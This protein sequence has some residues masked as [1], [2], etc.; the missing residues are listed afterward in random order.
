[1]ASKTFLGSTAAA[2]LMA[3]LTGTPARAA[4]DFKITEVYT[5]VDGEDG[6][7]DW[8]ELT[9]FGDTTGNIGSYYYDDSPPDPTHD[10]VLPN[11]DVAPCESVIVLIEGLDDPGT[12][13][14]NEEAVNIAD[15]YA[16]WGLTPADV[17]V[18][19]TDGGSLGGSGDGA[20][21]FDNNLIISNLIDSLEYTPASYGQIG[22]IED[23]H[24]TGPLTISSLGV[25]GAFESAGL[26]F[27]AP[28]EAHLIGS[29]GINICNVPEPTSVVLMLLGLAGLL[30][31]RRGN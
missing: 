9:N 7:T 2:M 29:P 27:D 13:D 10:F 3:L 22:T 5:G 28:N 4:A 26:A 6:T 23:A 31:I 19:A 25:H 30:S 16:F 20:F 15:F 18:G 21:V 11:F 14:V 17:Q 24:G 1:M 12:P 8:F